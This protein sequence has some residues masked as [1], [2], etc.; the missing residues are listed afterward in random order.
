MTDSRG[1]RN[2]NPGNIRKSSIE[3]LGMSSL[4]TDPEFVM[5]VDPKYGI[6]AIAKIMRT[7]QRDGLTSI[8]QI[9]DRWAPPVE[10]NSDAYVQDV[11]VRTGMDPD[12]DVNYT[13][14][15]PNL[16]KAIIIHENGFNP[17]SDSTINLGVAMA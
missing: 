1:F 12:Q 17:Y 11:A 16:V 14:I 6:R 7:Y 4:Q 5:F 8:R 15:M 9:I 13:S 2:C 3:W 10:N